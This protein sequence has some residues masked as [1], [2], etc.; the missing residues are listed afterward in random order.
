MEDPAINPNL[1]VGRQT[2]FHIAVKNKDLQC[3][4]VLL[5]AEA[6]PDIA[7]AKGITAIHQAAL[8]RQ[9]EIVHLILS[10]K[11]TIPLD[12]DTFRDYK[13][14]TAR[15]LL[16][17]NCPEFDLPEQK[18]RKVDF[19][20]LRYYLDANDEKNFLINLSQIN[21]NESINFNEL[22]KIASEH[23]LSEAI[24]KLISR[25]ELVE[26]SEAAEIAVRRGHYEVLKKILNYDCHIGK[27]LLILACQELSTPC[28]RSLDYQKIRL[29]CLKIIL[30]Q[31]DVDVRI[32]DG[33]ICLFRTLLGLIFF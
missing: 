33:I 1:E 13:Q 22:I 31:Q 5:S 29:K 30:K 3:V 14:Q 28:R 23:N 20:L 21:D 6:R 12:I 32:E 8:T 4:K 24:V 16:K 27:K 18:S 17:Q 25:E 10:T 7:N 11:F 19:N 26:M 9:K 2:A 15:D